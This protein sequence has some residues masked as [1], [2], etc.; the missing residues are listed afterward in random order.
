LALVAFV[1]QMGVIYL[2]PV[3][4]GSLLRFA[5]IGLT[6]TLLAVVVW[7]NRQQQGMW[8]LG[9]GLA[10]NCVVMLANGGY[11][12]ITMQAL[13]GAGKAQLVSSAAPGTLVL[14]SKDILLPLAETRLWFL[15]DIFVIPPPFPIPT[16]FSVGDALLAVGLVRFVSGVFGVKGLHDTQPAT[17]SPPTSIL[18]TGGTRVRT[19]AS[20]PHRR[21]VDRQ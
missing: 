21:G 19:C 4:G 12:P 3:T 9:L 15:S 11:M 17:S 6:Y 18:R 10:A 5:T 2:T 20:I 16:I 1:L 14:S 7:R 8:L 13:A